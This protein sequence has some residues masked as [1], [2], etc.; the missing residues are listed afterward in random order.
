M[1]VTGLLIT[2]IK[3]KQRSGRTLSRHVRTVIRMRI[4][5][6]CVTFAIPSSRVVARCS[7]S[8]RYIE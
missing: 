5:I 8:Q 7:R 3:V 4:L 6:V 2:V 1:P